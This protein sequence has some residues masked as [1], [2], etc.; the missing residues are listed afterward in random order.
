MKK[1]LTIA[2][3]ALLLFGLSKMASANVSIVPKVEKPSC[4]EGYTFQGELVRKKICETPKPW[5][6]VNQRNCKVIWSW[7]GEC[8]KDGDTIS[9][10]TPPVVVPGIGLIGDNLV[11]TLNS[12]CKDTMVAYTPWGNC[13]RNY[14][15]PFQMRKLLLNDFGM[16]VINGCRPTAQQQVDQ[17]R[18]C[19]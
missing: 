13:Q 14:K 16:S 9:T 11:A 6:S 19:K 8:V 15:Q 2:S 5:E 1:L 3:L 4:D 17:F 7:V 10:T 18:D 12:Y